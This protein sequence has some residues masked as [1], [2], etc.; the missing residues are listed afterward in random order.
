MDI[1]IQKLYEY[2]R[3]VSTELYRLFSHNLLTF[4]CQKETIHILFFGSYNENLSSTTMSL[5]GSKKHELGRV[6]IKL[7]KVLNQMSC[8]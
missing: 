4:C 2:D 8:R 5:T 3:F 7:V 6:N 1:E